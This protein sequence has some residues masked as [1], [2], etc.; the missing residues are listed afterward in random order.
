MVSPDLR[1]DL[2]AV[3]VAGKAYARE[4]HA[5]NLTAFLRALARPGV[6]A[7]LEEK[8]SDSSSPLPNADGDPVQTGV[9][10]GGPR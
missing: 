7:L 10:S 8:K 2:K 1:A 5:V 9:P 3:A 4:S 6:Q